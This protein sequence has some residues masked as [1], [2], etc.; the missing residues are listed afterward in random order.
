MTAEEIVELDKMMVEY[1][2]GSVF[3]CENEVID[4][5]G[6]NDRETH[7][8]IEK[9]VTG[10]IDFEYFEIFSWN[11]DWRKNGLT[12]EKMRLI[13]RFNPDIVILQECT[14]YD[15]LKFRDEYK[16]IVWYG[17]GKDGPLGIGIFS[18]KF[19]FELSPSY[20]YTAPFRYVVPYCVR[21]DDIHFTLFAV[22]TKEHIHTKL[23]SGKE[24]PDT[25]HNLDYVDNIN[26]AIDFYHNLFKD[27]VV[28]I[29]DYNSG[30]LQQ[31]RSYE[32]LLIVDK[33]ASYNVYNCTKLPDITYDMD[34]EFLP[35]FYHN[36]DC[37][38]AYVDDYCFLSN[39]R[40]IMKPGAFH[41][42]VPE[43]WLDYSDHFPIM[44]HIGFKMKEP[45][46]LKEMI[47]EYKAN[48][49]KI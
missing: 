3:W 35:T 44:L 48:S 8:E 28:L 16:N 1:F 10:N 25:L 9:I 40:H 42:G 37:N 38:K 26:K 4:L 19:Q 22:W 20:S 18:N 15:C 14:Y 11:C 30:D 5:D 27:P 13:K 46:T 45:K 47:N 49:K 17:D 21:N 6:L 2:K 34:I 33:L 23:D 39:N 32:H 31:R 12:K 7:R 43:K 36:Y 29:G 24:L 41:I